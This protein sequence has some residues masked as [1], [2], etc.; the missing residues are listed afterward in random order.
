MFK[1][2]LTTVV[3]LSSLPSYSQDDVAI[4]C[5]NIT[6]N[7]L[8]YVNGRAV[9]DDD[10]Y[11]GTSIKLTLSDS[12][13]FVQ[14]TGRVSRTDEI[15]LIASSKDGWLTFSKIFND[16]MKIY[17]IYPKTM[18]LSLLEIQTHIASGAPQ[19]RSFMAQCRG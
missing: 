12:G 17:T 4:T 15:T 7:S 6:G 3:L 16:V 8:D 19:V 1:V 11:S 14:Y 18:V 10:G 9:T 13:S 2:F 5:T